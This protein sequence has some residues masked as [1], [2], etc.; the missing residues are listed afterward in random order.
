MGSNTAATGISGER[1]TTWARLLGVGMWA[2]QILLALQ[3]AYVGLLK[4]SG[5][6]AM[7]TLFATIGAG[8][9]FRY[10]VGALEIVG[11]IGLLIPRLSGLAALC[12]VGLMLGATATQVFII[13][14]DQWVPVSVLLVSALVAWGPRPSIQELASKLWR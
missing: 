9:W 13:G 14:H 7:V 5:S 3:F 10:V 11:A 8:Q 12:L 6:P 1:R 2:L 4:V